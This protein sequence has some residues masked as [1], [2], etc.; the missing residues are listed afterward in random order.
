MKLYK[1]T[2]TVVGRRS[3]YSLYDVG[4]S[5]Y[6]KGDEFDHNS[7]VGFIY[8]WGLPGK[9]AAK[10]RAAATKKKAPAKK[11]PAKKT[12]AKKPAKK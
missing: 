6:A 1:G 8:C 11:A 10:A 2:A 9:T 7:A 3:P 4:L 12:A 5:T